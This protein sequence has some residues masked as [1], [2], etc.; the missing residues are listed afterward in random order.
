MGIVGAMM[1]V[2]L[3]MDTVLVTGGAG[4]IGSH[5]VLA[6][7]EAGR[8]VVVLDDLSTGDR[9]LVPDGVPLVVGDVADAGLVADSLRAHRVGTVMH[10]AGSIIV[11]ESVA[12]PLKYYR[13]NTAASR[14]LIETCLATGVGRF[15]FSSTAAVYGDPPTRVVTEETPLCPVSPYG[16]SKLMVERMLADVEAACPAFRYAVLRYF[17]VAGADPAGRAGQVSP[18]AT[19]LIKVACEVLLARRQRLTIFG[20]DY[21]TPDGTCVRDY[22]HVADLADAHVRALDHLEAGGDSAVLNC[23]YGRGYSVRQVTDAVARAAGRPLAVEE[24]P[25]RPGDPVELIADSG[26]LRHLL[27][28]RPRFD[29]LDLIVRH[30]LNWEGRASGSP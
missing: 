20:V 17:N 19:H 14:T 15:I 25:R 22:I 30:A 5:A 24:G 21:P 13:N 3:R 28:W 23:G 27:G 11:P 4:Y 6:L 9:A 29:D 12:D 7:L 10:F 2:G 26:R 8:P 16:W 1:F 18:N